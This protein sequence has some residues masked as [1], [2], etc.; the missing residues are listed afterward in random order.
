[1]EDETIHA[2][3]IATRHDS[4]CELVVRSLE[5]G[6][7]VYV[8][9]PLALNT[10]QLHRIIECYNRQ[11]LILTV[12]YNRRF[13]AHADLI[14][15][16]FQ[17]RSS[18]MAVN[19]RINAGFIPPDSWVH[20]PKVGGGR[21]IGEA[22]HF[23]D[24][25][26]FLIG[27][28]PV[29]VTASALSGQDTQDSVCFNIDYEDGSLASVQYLALGTPE[30]PKERCEVYADQS[31]AILDD[32]RETV[33]RGRL[34]KKRLRSRQDKGFDRAFEAFLHAVK[35]G[36]GPPIPVESLFATSQATLAVLESLKSNK[37]VNL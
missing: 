11:P 20:D 29:R 18:P 3:F 25:A 36:E 23:V 2:V 12:G 21:I 16:Y 22:C 10:V 15:Q 31:I 30:V 32:F 5:A 37:P 14:R 35:T 13:S 4:H 26:G 9:K 1:M 28:S 6:R 34:G 17:E 7:H 24:L 27:S 8:E 19:Y 33:C